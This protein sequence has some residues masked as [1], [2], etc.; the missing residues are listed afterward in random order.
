MIRLIQR[1]LIIPRGDTGTLSIPV[2]A[3][4][5]VGDVPIFTIFNTLTHRKVFEKTMEMA[6][7]TLTIEFKHGD[8][9]NLPVGQ[10]VWDIKFYTNPVFADEKLVGGTEV[11]SYY[12]AF[13]LPICEIRETGD[14]LLMADDA[15]TSTLRPDQI[16]LIE[17]AI[18]D[19]NASKSAAALSE[20]NAAT[21]ASNASTSELNAEQYA[22][23]ALLSKN[24][25]IEAESNA[26]ASATAAAASAQQA[27]ATAQ[28][29]HEEIPT[30][31]SD[32]IDDSGHYTK[33]VGGIPASDL[34]ETYL[35]QHQDISGKAN[36]ADLAAVATSGSYNDLL[37]KPTIPDIQIDSTSIVENGV[38]NIPVASSN[39]PGVV[40][41]NSQQGITLGSGNN[42]EIH[43]A[44]NAEIK[45]GNQYLKAIVPS[46]QE[47]AVFYGLAKAAG[48]DESTSQ[49]AMGTY[50]EPAKAA[51]RN[52]I[53]AAAAS[54]IPTLVS[55]LTNDSGYLTSYTETDPTVPAWA[56]A[57]NKPTYTAA[58]VG[59][60]TIAEMNTAI[61]TAIGNVNSFDMSVVQEL[62][63]QDISTHTI[64]LVPKTGETND[65][66]DEY[67]YIN[68]AWEMVGNTQ[69]DLSNYVQKDQIATMSTAGLVKV[70]TNGSN[71]VGIGMNASGLL[72]IMPA[73]EPSIK[74][75]NASYSPIVPSIQ[76]SSTFYGLAKAAGDTTQSQS[77]NAVGTYT[78]EA[79]AAIRSML[80][81]PATSDIPSVP[82]Q[83]VQI[84]STS[85]LDANG[86]AN[87]PIASTT[88]AGI[89]KVKNATANEAITNGGSCL[90]NG[91]LYC[92][93]TGNDNAVKQGADYAALISA[94]AQHKSVFY[95]LA[96][97]AGDTTQS[98][99]NNAVGTYTSE[100]KTAILS[101]LGAAASSD[102]PNVPVQDVQVNGTSI[103]NQGVASVPLA[104]YNTYGVVKL[105]AD[106]GIYLD[107]DGFLVNVRATQDEIK[108][109]SNAAHVITPARQHRATFYGLAKAAGDRTQAASDNAVGTYTD[110]AKDAIQNMLG[111]SDLLSTREVSTATAAHAINTLFLMDGKLYKATSAIAIGDA[112]VAGTNCQVVKADE[113]FVKNTDYAN[114]N[115]FGIV[116]PHDNSFAYYQG[117]LKLKVAEISDIKE[118]TNG[119]KA[120]APNAVKATAFYGLAQASGDTTQAQ[121]DNAVGT[122]T[123]TAATAI[124]TMLQVQEGL[125][126][127]RL[128]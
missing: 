49:E 24:R 99:S 57:Q 58:E 53:G 122:Y 2:L 74:S 52:M 5:N 63:S 20:T 92:V 86:I 80:D 3:G 117:S 123:T 1:R 8:T 79:K 51:I 21:S 65:V 114:G 44:S 125:E 67:V 40:G 96:K 85:I 106:L 112:V 91:I 121:S 94:A 68:N 9:V 95:G 17:A 69:I 118:G 105:S 97:A 84:N 102:I 47:N 70:M 42:L 88:S 7:S 116:R 124:K 76:H 23:D 101:M 111:I 60:P 87:I 100:A 90:I 61:G 109:G 66:Y 41:V 31:V 10:Y 36:S 35:T 37:N 14:N 30:K 104:D 82:V 128:I 27:A 78:D 15:P 55:Q 32:L 54:A 75:S 26:S 43:P 28:A 113:V 50:R 108:A 56:K 64:Y 6:D 126:V 19:I 12:A 45:S 93:G 77:A 98:Q 33:P 11:D 120:L 73:A 13:N 107:A 127:V 59:A 103:L 29:I 115:T 18:T 16:N 71:A 4:K 83:D 48:A 62:P 110:A 89:I 119:W 39:V 46:R 25:A 34:A 38:A 72:T 22:A 81:V